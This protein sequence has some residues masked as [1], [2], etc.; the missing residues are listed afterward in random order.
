MAPYR[1][2]HNFGPV[3]LSKKCRGTETCTQTRTNHPRLLHMMSRHR[4]KVYLLIIFRV[5]DTI[6]LIELLLQCIPNFPL[7]A[8]AIPPMLTRLKVEMNRYRPV[9]E[10]RWKG[11]RKQTAS[12]KRK[13]WGRISHAR[14]RDGCPRVMT[15]KSRIEHARGRVIAAASLYVLR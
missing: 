1:L 3:Y 10:R 14:T 11:R 6:W 13:D 8:S 4:P 7:S 12:R 5:L 15:Q 2:H 9:L